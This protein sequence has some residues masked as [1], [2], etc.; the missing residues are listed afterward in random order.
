MAD[1]LFPTLRVFG[2]Q[3]ELSA[4]G[5]AYSARRKQAKP[6]KCVTVFDKSE[7]NPPFIIEGGNKLP[8]E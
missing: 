4:K 8:L 6:V 2:P 3:A 7:H 5:R 1:T